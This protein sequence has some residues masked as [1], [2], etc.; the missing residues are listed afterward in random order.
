MPASV[1]DKGGWPLLSISL[2][3][4]GWWRGTWI[5]QSSREHSEH[6]LFGHFSAVTMTTSCH[7]P[8]E[9]TEWIRVSL[10]RY[11]FLHK[12]NKKM[13]TDTYPGEGKGIFTPVSTGMYKNYKYNPKDTE[14][15]LPNF[16]PITG[17]LWVSPM[18]TVHS[19]HFHICGLSKVKSFSKS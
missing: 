19:V 5:E 3:L 11:D 4:W 7:V 12:R 13:N 2:P 9:K 18:I 8:A 10:F 17:F 1:W 15:F 16:W 6:F 14:S